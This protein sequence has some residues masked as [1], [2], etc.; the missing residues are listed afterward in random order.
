MEP[1]G[2]ELLHFRSPTGGRDDGR[3]GRDPGR[4][5]RAERSHEFLTN[6]DERIP[7]R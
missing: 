7:L 3:L 5:H 4:V 6:H 1:A 2:P